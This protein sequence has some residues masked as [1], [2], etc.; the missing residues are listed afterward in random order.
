[1]ASAAHALFDAAS[2]PKN[3]SLTS[4]QLQDGFAKLFE[5]LECGQER[6]TQC[7]KASRWSKHNCPRRHRNSVTVINRRLAA[8]A[9]LAGRGGPGGRG[10][11]QGGGPPAEPLTSARD[12]LLRASID[13]QGAK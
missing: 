10:G 2:D 1:M 4:T 5:S 7:R 3:A 6:C 9:G 13:I 12:G 8:K 11:P